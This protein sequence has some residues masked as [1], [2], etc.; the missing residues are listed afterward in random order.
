MRNYRFALGIFKT[1]HFEFSFLTN[2]HNLEHSYSPNNLLNY[3]HN[4]LTLTNFTPHLFF[5]SLRGMNA[6]PEQRGHRG[7]PPAPPPSPRGFPSRS[8]PSTGRTC[9][10]WLSRGW[11]SPLRPDPS[12]SWAP[13][14]S[15]TTTPNST[16]ATTASASLRPA[17]GPGDR[18]GPGGTGRDR[19][20]SGGWR[21]SQGPASPSHLLLSVTPNL[22]RSHS[23]A[24]SPEFL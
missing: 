20:R 12:G 8:N 1:R 3:S 19:R 9:A 5:T 21:S 24:A 22:A 11:T 18:G 14:S 15:G 16:G 23:Q 4:A 10:W 13:P 2:F 17:E 7:T 6:M